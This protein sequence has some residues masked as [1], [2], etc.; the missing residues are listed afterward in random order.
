MSREV[1]LHH[2]GFN[3]QAVLSALSELFLS[4]LTALRAFLIGQ[5]EPK[6]LRFVL[7]P[8]TFEIPSGG[9]ILRSTFNLLTLKKVK[10]GKF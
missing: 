3:Y 5:T 7:K 9:V 4:F 8:S 1:N 2:S 10:L 6:I